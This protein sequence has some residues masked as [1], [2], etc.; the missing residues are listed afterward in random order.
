MCDR[1]VIFTATISNTN[2]SITTVSINTAVIFFITITISGMITNCHAPSLPCFTVVVIV[3]LLV[4]FMQIAIIAFIHTIV[5]TAVTCVVS[6][7]R[8]ID[9]FYL[10]G[11]RIYS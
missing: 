10:A 9:R 1:S 7:P 5:F 4:I 6:W 2:I 3:S 11:P 8:A